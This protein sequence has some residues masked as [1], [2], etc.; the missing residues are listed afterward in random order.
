MDLCNV[1]LWD[2]FCEASQNILCVLPQES[3]GI[4][5]PW[6]KNTYINIQTLGH[7]FFIS[8]GVFFQILAKRSRKLM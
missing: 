3:W 5:Y 6:A 7:I 8:G 2:I 1:D 4:L